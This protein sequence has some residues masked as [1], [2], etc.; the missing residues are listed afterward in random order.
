[1]EFLYFLE[2]MRTQWLN[3]IMQTL[4]Y[5]GDE[6]VFLVCAIIMFWCFDKRKGYYLLAVGFAGTLINQF[7]K[8]LFRVPRPWV[9]DENFTIVE[10][11]RERATGYS[12]P[13]G[14]TQVSVGTFGAIAAT[15]K[16]RVLCA[17]CLLIVVLVPFSRMYL[18][19][20]T[21]KDILVAAATAVAL[22]ML[23]RPI[24]TA[25]NEK[26]IPIIF[27]VLAIMSALFTLYV[28]LYPFASDIDSQNLASGIKNA[29][30]LLG[31]V[32]GILIVYIV[33]NMW[34]HFPTKAVWW[35]QIL[36]TALGLCAVLA[37]KSGLK[38]PINMVFGQSIGT[39]VRYFL[40]VIVAGIIWP[41][42]FRWF[43]GLGKR[44]QS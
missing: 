43:S 25:K 8:L 44:E 38:G 21:P 32:T 36:K 29:Y 41:L 34:L 18:G 24:V 28:E 1:M 9:I 4:T 14:H 20:H 22:I 39:A 42:T 17:I 3:A 27:A 35:A 11:A 19:V 26:I 30:T 13:S 6:L 15:T 10:Q 33:D 2:S 23:F 12:F 16:K 5:M 31:A 37:V 7:C 40:M